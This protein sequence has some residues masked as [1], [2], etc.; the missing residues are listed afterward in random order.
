MKTN[1][2]QKTE[3]VCEICGFSYNSKNHARKCEMQRPR[4]YFEF[5]K[6]KYYKKGQKFLT[7]LNDGSIWRCCLCEITGKMVD[8]HRIIPTA[9]SIETGQKVGIIELQN[10]YFINAKM[11]AKWNILLN[12]KEKT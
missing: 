1:I 9:K 5:D 2:I 12:K 6:E 8:K 7:F 10:P 4:K 11:V 3:Y